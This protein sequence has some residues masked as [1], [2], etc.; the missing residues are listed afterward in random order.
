V[1][2]MWDFSTTPQ[3]QFFDTATG[4]IDYRYSFLTFGSWFA[5]VCLSQRSHA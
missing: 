3:M 1:H 5:I 2:F 4:K